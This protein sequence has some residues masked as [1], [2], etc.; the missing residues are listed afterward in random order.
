MQQLL[1]G[2][3]AAWLFMFAAITILTLIGLYKGKR[4][5]DLTQKEMIIGMAQ[6]IGALVITILF[7]GCFGYIL[8]ITYS[9]LRRLGG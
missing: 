3:G 1:A 6:F 5:G 2:F 8:V 7:T 4:E 9:V